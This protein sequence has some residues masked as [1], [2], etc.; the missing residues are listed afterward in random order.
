[1]GVY[2]CTETGG[3]GGGGYYRYQCYVGGGGGRRYNTVGNNVIYIQFKGV[4]GLV[5]V[6]LRKIFKIIA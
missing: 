2:R 6:I 1:M 4:K 3:E 5:T